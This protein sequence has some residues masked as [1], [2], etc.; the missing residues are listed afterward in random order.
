MTREGPVTLSHMALLGLLVLLWGSSFPLIKLALAGMSPSHLT[1]LRH[2]IASAAFLPLLLLSRSRLWPRR[3]DVLG[4][5]GLGL[6]GITVYHLGL[7]YGE[8][9]V[10]AG[11]TSLIVATAPAL[12]AL[13]AWRL[14]GERMPLW[15]WVGS[16]VAIAGV[17]LITVGDGSAG[18]HPMAAVVFL[19]P[20][21]A[22]F[23]AVLQR[24]FLQ[25][26][27]P[28]EVTAFFTW[29]GTL[30][31]LV[32]LPGL[33][34]GLP[35]TGAAPLWATVYLGVVPSAIAYT[36]F[37][38]V[39]VHVTAPTAASF[40]Y[41]IPAAALL[42]SWWWLGETPTW[43]TLVGGTVA[44]AGLLLIQQAKRGPASEDAGPPRSELLSD[45]HQGAR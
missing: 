3:E 25:R 34:G 19:A 28:V 40:L 18:F 45:A 5:I 17:A 27:R 14:V 6:V 15:G 11:A 35:G 7:N 26:Y 20:L 1:L 43:L 32:F 37:A 4:F 23:F 30:P 21:S 24:S 31:L 9:H 12:T 39:L 13:V 42:M 8:T 22:A 36:V 29:G 41:L 44:V 2:L 16:A 10:S 33:L 38:F